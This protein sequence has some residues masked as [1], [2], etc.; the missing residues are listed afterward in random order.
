MKKENNVHD[1]KGF[2]A[3]ILSSRHTLSLALVLVG[4]VA[5]ASPSL[6]SQQ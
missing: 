3:G 5:M 6:V 2:L 4:V 1:I